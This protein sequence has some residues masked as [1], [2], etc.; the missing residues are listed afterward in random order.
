VLHQLLFAA[1]R[2]SQRCSPYC[3]LANNKIFCSSIS[4]LKRW[5]SPWDLWSGGCG[6]WHGTWPLLLQ[7]PKPSVEFTPNKMR[8]RLEGLEE[9]LTASTS[10]QQET[11]ERPDGQ[12][13]TICSQDPSDLNLWHPTAFET[14]NHNSRVSSSWTP[15]NTALL[16]IPVKSRIISKRRKM[17][18]IR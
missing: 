7:V 18:L 6:I 14:A 17:S 15:R 2:N 16:Q 4:S 10:K 11:H 8:R 12:L 5:W 9:S 1:W 13:V 3:S